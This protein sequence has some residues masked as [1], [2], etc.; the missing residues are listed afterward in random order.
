MVAAR[1]EAGQDLKDKVAERRVFVKRELERIEEAKQAGKLGEAEEANASSNS[2]ALRQVHGSG[3]SLRRY[4]PP[5][6]TPPE[7][8]S[9]PTP[10]PSADSHRTRSPTS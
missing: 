10:A 8:A 1:A 3:R 2:S 7:P 9:A 4:S 5:P 6:S